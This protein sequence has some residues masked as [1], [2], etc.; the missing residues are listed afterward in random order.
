MDPWIQ[1]SHVPDEVLKCI[2]IGLLCVQD[3]ASDRPTMSNVV[4]MLGSD[5]VS[6][7]TPLCS[8][9]CVRRTKKEGGISSNAS[10]SVT[11]N[12]VTLS[13]LIPR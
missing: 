9:F 3:K 6:L 13:E 12:E 2:Q 8:S 5:R 4:H 7:P 11:F 1:D 10:S